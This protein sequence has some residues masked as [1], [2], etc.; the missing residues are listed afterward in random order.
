MVRRFL[1]AAG[2]LLIA[3]LLILLYLM[4]FHGLRIERDGSG[5]RPM[6]WFQRAAPQSTAV[7]TAPIPPAPPVAV[8]EPTPAPSLPIPYWT[9][10][11]GPRRDGRYEEIP[12][13]VSWPASGP[14]RLWR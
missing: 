9:D 12:N 5:S 7:E 14:K 8:V 2:A 4:R 1:K 6:F 3:G 11:R 10:F 13:I